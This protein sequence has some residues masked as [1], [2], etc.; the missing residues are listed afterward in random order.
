MEIASSKNNWHYNPYLTERARYLRKHFTKSEAY[1][2]KF[3]LRGSLMGVKFLRQ[4][5]VLNYIADF[6][7]RDLLLIIECDG[8]SHLI[9]GAAEKDARRDALLQEVGFKVLR[10]DD[11]MILDHLT[12][13]LGIVAQEVE[14]RKKQ[15]WQ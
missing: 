13:T 12:T 1:L 5:P 6:M 7:C 4:R 8:A 10:F 2:W 15:F 14:E 9:E 3:G 11:S